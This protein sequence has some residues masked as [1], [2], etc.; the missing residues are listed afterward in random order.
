MTDAKVPGDAPGARAGQAMGRSASGAHGTVWDL[1]AD[2]FSR[3]RRGEQAGLDQ[4]VR[5]MTPVLWH[6]ARAYDLN[7]ENVEDVVQTTWLSL[8]KHQDN[9][10]DAQ[11]LTKWLITATRREAARTVQAGRRNVA[12][13]DETIA[14]DLP[15]QRSAENEAVACDESHR[16]W[17]AVATLAPRCQRL[18][19]VIAFEDRPDYAAL[20]VDLGMPRGSIGPTRNRCLAKLRIILQ[21]E[22]EQ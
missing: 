6:V 14:R 18:L 9:V 21:T 15:E 1:A 19:R 22:G 4:L 3:W 17:Q 8:V 2:A 13:P 12:L 11:A 16:L 7:R 20:S 5:V 10:R